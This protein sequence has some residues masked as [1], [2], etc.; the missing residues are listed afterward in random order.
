MFQSADSMLLGNLQK[1]SLDVMGAVV[2]I[3]M[4]GRPGLDWILRIQNPNMCTVFEVA[5][6]SKDQ[7]LDWMVAIKET[8]QNASARVST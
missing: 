4:I 3:C 1:G 5:C 7:A 6:P 2:E 8:A